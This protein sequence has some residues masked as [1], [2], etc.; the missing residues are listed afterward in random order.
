VGGRRGTETIR[1]FRER[2]DG[3]DAP[4]RYGALMT[5][6]AP[7]MTTEHKLYADSVRKFFAA[8]LVPQQAAWRKAGIVDPAFWGKAAEAGLLGATIDE[9]HGGGGAP[10]SFDAI[11]C[12][13]LG[14]AGDSG[15]GF[16][17]QSIVAHYF[18]SYATAEQKRRWLP[19]L[20]SGERI[21]AIA[22]TEPGT[23]SDLQSIQT[24][25]EPDGDHYRLTGA[26][27]F[28]T[29]GQCANL[30]V[31]VAKTDRS[32]KAKGISLLVVETEELEGLSFK[33]GRNLEK[34]GMKSADTSELFFEDAR[35]PVANLLGGKEGQG[36]FQLM[37][38]LPWERL[39]IGI[40]ALGA[41]DFALGETL[42]Y[43]KE[44][45]AFGKRIFDFQNTRFKLAELKT[46]VEFARA[47]MNEC[48]VKQDAG[49]L[50]A[51]TASM[52]K[53]YGSELQTEVVDECLQLFG[54]YGYMLEYPIA[55]AWTDARV[56]KIYGG[57]NEIMKELIARQLEQ[58]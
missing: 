38:E 12:Y 41:M 35:I 17:I 36:F 27:T 51:A 39:I 52:A 30:I 9:A 19:K 33:R 10:Y 40:A 32:A 4:S 13:E 45:R 46:K 54:G 43:V 29:N 37:T 14:R 5:P 55:H 57:T 20:A 8:E 11:T 1:S 58:L 25:A 16:A 44:R 34:V 24:V 49:T 50:D 15:W 47:F 31:V 56:Q 6:D 3:P 21:A 26:K 7:W 53:W 42:R 18:M 22:M 28:I 2:G 23:G 48:I